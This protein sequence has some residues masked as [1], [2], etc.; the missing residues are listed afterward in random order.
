MTYAVI[1]YLFTFQAFL[2]PLCSQNA[3]IAVQC[4]SPES[5]T[6]KQ[7]QIQDDFLVL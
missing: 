7:S 1:A 4:V 2:T 3:L 6:E 5:E